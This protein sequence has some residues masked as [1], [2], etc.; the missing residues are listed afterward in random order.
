MPNKNDDDAKADKAGAQAEVPSEREFEIQ[1][2]WENLEIARVILDKYMKQDGVLEEDI[3]LKEMI[4]ADVLKRIG[5]C[6]ILKENFVA[7]I[8]EI[9]KTID[10]LEKR[11][12]KDCNRK[13]SETYYL[14][15]CVIGYEAKPN[16]AV[17]SKT[18]LQKALKIMG[19][20]NKSIPD[21]EIVSKKEIRGTMNMILEK[22]KDLEEEIKEVPKNDV[23]LIKATVTKNGFNTCKT[24]AKSQLGSVNVNK[25]GTF[26]KGTSKTQEIS[27]KRLQ[28]PASN[29]LLGTEKGDLNKVEKKVQCAETE[30]EK[31]AKSKAPLLTSK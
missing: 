30:T 31:T 7:A 20:I 1:V 17:E 14:M 6:E 26:G 27:S 3:N 5:D 15:G 4:L 25:L 9:Q 24:F 8:Q 16:A 10:I 12:D 11:S 19:E 18:M 2:A 22:I 23:E 28:E 21:T 29:N 13:L